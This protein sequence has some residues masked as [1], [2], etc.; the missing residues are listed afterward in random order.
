[1]KK[2]GR[3]RSR[4]SDWKSLMAAVRRRDTISPAEI[5]QLVGQ[6]TDVSLGKFK[7]SGV[8]SRGDRSRRHPACRPVGTVREE[9]ENPGK[10]EVY[11]RQTQRPPR[12]LSLN[13]RWPLPLGRKG[14]STSP[15]AKSRTL[16]RQVFLVQQLLPIDLKSTRI[17]PRDQIDNLAL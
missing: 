6:Y 4:V 17:N 9:T 14:M 5:A 10:G 12:T 2:R 1:M 13:L 15:T 3:N 16:F 8:F 7:G 11:S